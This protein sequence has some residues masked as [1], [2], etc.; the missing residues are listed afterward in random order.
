MFKLSFFHTNLQILTR[1]NSEPTQYNRYNFIASS[2]FVLKIEILYDIA[3]SLVV[4][5]VTM[6]VKVFG[7]PH[8]MENPLVNDP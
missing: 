6:S 1:K 4:E 7:L 5:G 2:R 3:A 8:P